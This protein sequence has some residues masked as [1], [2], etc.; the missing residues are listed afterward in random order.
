MGL[1][2]RESENAVAA[3]SMIP[4]I[5]RTSNVAK[6]LLQVSHTYKVPLQ[7]LDFNLLET[8][9]FIKSNSDGPNEEWTELTP[10][11]LSRL[12]ESDFLNPKFEMKQTHE[13][14]IFEIG[15]ENPLDSMS[16]SIG[17]N[18]TLCK[19]YLTIKAGSV[20]H[21]YEG[22]DD[23]FIHCILKKKLR[24]NLMVGVFDAMMLPNLGEMLAKIRVERNYRFS[25]QERYLVAQS[26][27]P[28]ETVND[29]LILHYETKR[30][31]ID[32]HDR[33]DY[34]KR[35]Y[36]MSAI[37]DELLIEYIKPL[38]G[39]IGRNCRGELILPKEPI[40]KHEP[41]FSTGEKIIVVDTPKSIEYR[42]AAGGYVTFEGGV[43][44]IHS[45]ME[46]SEISFRT[47][48]SIDTQLDADVCINV[49]EKDS[50][51]DAIGQG[52]EVTVN[53]INIE[54]NIG[55]NAKVTAKK[56]TVDGQVHQSAVIEA[57]ELSVN[58]LKGT[59]YGKEVHITRL[60]LG[61]VE[62]DKVRI[63]Q[64][65]GGKI[66]ARE[67]VIDVL[68]SHVKISASHRIEIGKIVGGENQLI[69][70]PMINESD[71]S[72]KERS[73]QMVQVKNS[74]RD[75]K[76]EVEGYEHTWH[77]NVHA[78]ED[79]KRKLAHYK[80]N[81]VKMP[82]AFVQ[83]Y[84]QYQLFKEKLEAL[85]HELQDKEDQYLFLAQTHAA[86]Q[87]EIYDA[88]II[89][90]DRWR[91]HNEIVFKLIDP[92]VEVLYVPSE[93]SEERV[94]GLHQDEDGVFSIKVMSQ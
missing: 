59:A 66:R 54:G 77:E 17:G 32:E 65:T 14:E 69:I 21:Y 6:E 26:P 45:E 63:T 85:R 93:N 88:R 7:S 94:L 31:N 79:L 30:H 34:S 16:M 4:V 22:F 61:S 29:N 86:L 81:G 9:T 84:Q 44:D 36:I 89:N 41:T 64:A 18:G 71:E 2:E 35:G 3:S 52:M 38:K 75:I 28:I 87:A 60:E 12:K 20:A 19:I 42:A 25:V 5:V 33:V 15:G 1:F 73:D 68:G 90:R 48:G 74:I 49:K 80:A 62:A 76:K 57:D 39:E 53:A 67:V 78:M 37:K 47:T 13:I 10:D 55:P 46:V 8:Q 58:V 72:L 23:D 24:A 11:E 83:K 82:V 43:Y 50:M 92:P 70:D 56:A 40:I 51:K 91:N 27:E